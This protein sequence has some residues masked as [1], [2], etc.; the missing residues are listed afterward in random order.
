MS[1]SSLA[2]PLPASLAAETESARWSAATRI[3]FRFCFAFLVLYNLPFPLDFIPW[4]SE[5]SWMNN[6]TA[7]TVPRLYFRNLSWW[8]MPAAYSMQGYHVDWNPVNSITNCR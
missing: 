1:A 5:G 7:G 3:A 2:E 4:V 6:Q 8:D